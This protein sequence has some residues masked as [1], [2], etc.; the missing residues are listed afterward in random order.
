LCARST[1][2][3]K[4]RNLELQDL[5][6]IQAVKPDQFMMIGGGAW[7]RTNDLRIMS[8]PT[9]SDSGMTRSGTTLVEQIISMHP[10]VGAGG[11][12]NFWNERGAACYRSGAAGND[13]P[14]VPTQNLVSEFLAKAAADYLGVLRAIA[15]TVARVTDKMPFNFLWATL[16]PRGIPTRHLHPLPP[17]CNRHG[18]VDPS[19]SFQSEH[20]VSDRRYRIGRV[21]PQFR[22]ISLPKKFSKRS[23]M[24]VG[25]GRERS[26]VTPAGLAP[27][28]PTG[29]KMCTA[30]NKRSQNLFLA[31]KW[32]GMC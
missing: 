12:L 18:A 1:S 13:T 4:S 14:F 8:R 31:R 23:P 19:N 7:T 25:G 3:G 15:P 16:N 26:R 20:A 21:L 22:W 9:D 32:S 30:P 29:I 11:E 17:R 6:L 2:I 28:S 10:E 24:S 27:S 5:A